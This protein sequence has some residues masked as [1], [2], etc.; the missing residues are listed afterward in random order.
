MTLIKATDPRP[1]AKAKA[2]K[3]IVAGKIARLKLLMAQ[4]AKINLPVANSAKSPK[5]FKPCCLAGFGCKNSSCGL[6]HPQKCIY[7]Q[8]C[9]FK[10]NGF[11]L[12]GHPEDRCK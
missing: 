8:N 12:Y 10:R 3:A 11:C 9:H 1:K 5:I 2:K 6:Y 7:G 4:F